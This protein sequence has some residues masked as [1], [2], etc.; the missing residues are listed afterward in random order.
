M[1]LLRRKT[2]C[3][4]ALSYTFT[5]C[6]RQAVPARVRYNG[7]DM[8]RFFYRMFLRLMRT[9]MDIRQ[10]L[11]LRLYFNRRKENLVRA[12][13]SFL[14]LRGADLS[15]GDLREANLIR[16]DLSH[17][18]LRNAN[19][20][21][22][23]L[24]GA[25]LIGA[26][27]SGAQMTGAAVTAVQLRQAKSLHGLTLPNGQRYDAEQDFPAGTF[28]QGQADDPAGPSL[29]WRDLRSRDLR[30]AQLANANLRG[31][32][33]SGVDLTDANLNGAFLLNANLRGAILLRADLRGANLL[34]SDL[35]DAD[36]QQADLTYALVTEQQ[37][38]TAV[39]LV[40]ATLPDGSLPQ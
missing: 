9:A 6:Q 28:S 18:N 21:A 5:P 17:A 7:D 30:A 3:N 26:D 40:G 22:A 1:I 39:S 37:L 16:A 11:F 20:L 23:D 8:E 25:R 36:L 34:K 12:D 15:D 14:D 19:L 32:N 10:K 2:L 38:A 29:A 13:L 24:S 35:Q 27:L 4:L 33:L 31:A